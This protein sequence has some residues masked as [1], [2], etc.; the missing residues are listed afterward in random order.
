MTTEIIQEVKGALGSLDAKVKDAMSGLEAFKT[1][2]APKLGKLDALDLAKLEKLEKSIG[3]GIELSQKAEAR[4]KAAEESQ[5]EME[6]QLKAL[7]IAFNRAPQGGTIEEKAEKVAMLRK[8]AVN[9]FARKGGDR[10]DFE[11]F[12]ARKAAEDPEFKALSVGSDPNGGYLVMPEFGSVIK[13]KVFESSPIR[14]L[15]S[16]VTIST[17]S[18]EVVVDYDEAGAG[19][20]SESGTRS[21][22]STPTF[23]KVSVPVHE[24][25]ANP[26]ATQTS[27]DDAVVDIEAW[28]NEKVADKFARTE[29]AAF[30]TGTGVG[31]PRGIMSYTAGTTISSGQVEQVVS[32]SATAFTYDGLVDLQNALK[33]AYQANAVFLTKRANNAN[34]MK[35]KDGNGTPIFNMT[36]DKNAGLQPTV[37]GKPVYFANDVAAV[38]ANALAAAYGDF[39]Q[40][41]QVVD[42]Q[43]IRI[44]RDPYSDKPFVA[45]YTTR[46]VGGGV[47][48][49]EAVKLQKIST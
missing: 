17:G 13:T 40:A 1:E 39:R 34:L 10:V 30:V 7:E 15:A 18:Y 47:V 14:T 41:Y 26:K 4:V 32:G 46:R 35:I 25:Y 9:E 44:L 2:I 28:L 5:K 12:I 11:D 20:V 8:Q 22:T 49:F 19:W 36:Y 3:D 33:E 31:Q 23:G 24:M 16:V 6:T 37:M 21:T 42:R 45:F 27:L 48:N 38:A 43:G 29:A